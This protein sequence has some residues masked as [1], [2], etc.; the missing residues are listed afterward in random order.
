M[1]FA[2]TAL[3]RDAFL[4][5]RLMLAQPVAGYRAATDP[6]FL[7]ASVPAK[8]GQSVLELGCG[9]GVA[10][11]ALSRRVAGLDAHGVELQRDYAELARLNAAEN[12]L[13][14]VIHDGDLADMPAS[15]R[16]LSFDHVMANPPFY[17]DHA[18][19]APRDA[20]KARAQ[21]QPTTALSVWVDAALRR[22][23]PRGMVTLVH[24]AEAL[25]DILAALAGRA[26]DVSVL[27]LAARQGR[28]A[29]RVIVQ[30]VK[31][32]RGPLRLLAP[33]VVHEGAQHGA[34]DDAYS[35][36]ARGVLRDMHALAL[37]RPAR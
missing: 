21:Q 27:P 32:A 31:G 30:A 18:G 12:G 36:V 16:A 5:G 28:S 37:T 26:G 23:H 1:A 6:V 35:L 17:A 15:L 22:L 3:S 24:K 19:T 8:V 34:T 7:A 9:A 29:G 4:S 25:G 33:L 13:K 11:A 2:E 20:G 10:L 14:L